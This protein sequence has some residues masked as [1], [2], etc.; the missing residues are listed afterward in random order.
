MTPA[1]AELGDGAHVVQFYSNDDALI[2]VLARLVGTALVTGDSAVLCATGVHEK[3]LRK[4]L[5]ERGLD[6]TV[7]LAQ[8]RY[9]HVE[10]LQ[11]LRR[12]MPRGRIDRDEFMETVG[13]LVADARAVAE[14]EHVF[15]FGELVGVLVAEGNV[16]AALQLETLWNELMRDLP[17]ALCCGYPMQP[18]RNDRSA[19]P[20]LQVCGQ[21]SH[22]FPAER[23]SRVRLTERQANP[24]QQQGRAKRHTNQVPARQHLLD[25]AG[26]R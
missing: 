17:F 13:A 20:F 7:A 24:N 10:A 11:L 26:S 21:H 15:V 6:V 2:E 14:S 19:A 1:T 3:L 25:E 23:R 4:R 12:I 5:H 18:F 8:R 16:T 22:V 9:V